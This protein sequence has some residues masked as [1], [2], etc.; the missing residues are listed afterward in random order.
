M[1]L[2][3]LGHSLVARRFGIHVV[4]ITFWPL[5]GMARMSEIPEDPKI[6]GAVAL[7]GPAVNLV[8]AGLSGLV[9]IATLALGGGTEV[10]D[11]LFALALGFTMIN[12]MLGT[13]NLL[14]GF[15]M[16]GGRV[17][18]A[19]FAR[20]ASW[21]DATE[22]AVRVGRWVALAMVVVGVL[23]Q[24]LSLFLCVVAIAIFIWF[25]GARELFVVRLRHGRSPFGSAIFER[26]TE[27]ARPRDAQWHAGPAPHPQPAGPDPDPAVGSARRPDAE[28][29]GPESSRGF[30]D[31]DVRALERFHGRLPRTE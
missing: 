18:R 22:R 20:K 4:D 29:T 21:V 23:S 9:A 28:W 14:P 11:S 12:V 13:L 26:A 3:E 17:L 6:E 27:A 8:L 31:E 19:W 7:A 24:S 15:P 25:T 16:D 1:L 2:H 5:G 10:G 30:S